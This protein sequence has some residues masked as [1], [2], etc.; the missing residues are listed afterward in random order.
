[1]PTFAINAPRLDVYQYLMQINPTRA[2][3]LDAIPPVL[4]SRGKCEF[5]MTASRDDQIFAARK[6]FEL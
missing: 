2:P 6:V 5:C 3:R 4:F 1:M